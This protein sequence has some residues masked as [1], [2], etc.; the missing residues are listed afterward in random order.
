MQTPTADSGDGAS[1]FASLDDAKN[2]LLDSFKDATTSASQS[3]EGD[4]LSSQQNGLMVPSGRQMSL[5]HLLH[6]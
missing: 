3:V 2:S 6:M 4:S 1:V 5:L